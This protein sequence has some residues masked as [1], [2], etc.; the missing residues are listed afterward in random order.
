M[1]PCCLP[2][3]LARGL[4]FAG[5]C[6]GATA[7]C[8]SAFGQA[9]LSVVYTGRTLGYFRYPEQQSRANFDRCIDDPA[10]MSEATRQFAGILRAQVAGAQ[11]LVGMGDNFAMDLDARTF[12]DN[13]VRQ[14]K[15][16]WTWDYLSKPPTWI[17]DK[18]VKGD[19]AK[20]LAAGNGKIPA[21]NVACFLRWAKYDAIVP[22]NADFYYGPE[23]LRMLAR[24]LMT[25]QG[26]AFPKVAMLAANLAVTSV[27]PDANPRIPDYQHE[28]NLLGKQA[29]NY[30]VVQK[31]QGEEPIIQADIPDTVLPW[32]RKIAIHNAFEVLDANQKR[33]VLQNQPDG[34]KFHERPRNPGATAEVTLDYRGDRASQDSQVQNFQV[35]YRF[36]TVEFCPAKDGDPRDPYDLDLKKCTEL[37]IDADATKDGAGDLN[38]DLFYAAPAQVLQPNTNW[39]V[40]L[41]WKNPPVKNSLPLCQL[42]NVHA[43]FLQYPPN[44]GVQIP[45][46]LIK[47]S[48][49]GKIAIFGVVDPGMIASIGRLN[50]AWMNKDSEYDTQLEVLD[51]AV[52]LNQLMQ[53]CE[54][55]ED[56]K[57]ARKILLAHMPAAAASNL[58][59]NIGFHF[60]MVISQTDDAHET[61]DLQVSKRIVANPQRGTDERPP[62]LVTPGSVY[63]QRVPGKI[64]LIAQKATLNR[65]TGCNTGACA[66]WWSLTNETASASYAYNRPVGAG[67][68]LRE[69][70]RTALRQAGVKSS[71]SDPDP[72]E[73]WTSLQILERLATLRMQQ[74]LH[75][76][77]AMIQ[78]RDVFEAKQN[79][80][81]AITPQNLKEVVDRVYWKDDYALSLPLTGATL[82][83]VLQKS[84]ALAAEE[85]N[86]VNIDLERGRALAPLGVFQELATKAILV[87]SQPIQDAALYS[88]AV[89]DYLAFGDTGYTEFLTPAVPPA[90]RLLDFSKLHPI[91]NTVCL[92]IRNALTRAHPEF[93]KADCGPESLKASEYEDESDLKP[94]DTTAGYTAWRQFVAWAIP[95]FQY[96][97]SFPLYAGTSL[98][99]K[100]SQQKPRFSFRV[101]KTDL[102]IA[103]NQHQRTLLPITPPPGASVASI[104]LQASK[105]AGNPIPEVTAPDSSSFRY[106]N[107]TRFRWSGRRFDYFLMDD[108]AFAS[109]KTQ[110]TPFSPNYIRSLSSN[111]LG[112]EGGTLVRLFP[113]LK[114][115]ADLKLLVS[116]RFDTQLSSPLLSLTLHDAAFSN[117]LH[118]LNR[119]YRDLTKVGFRLENSNS[120]IEAG[121][122]GGE[123]FRLPSQYKFGNQVCQ[124][125]TGEDYHN[126]ILSSPPQ[127]TSP[128]YYS[129]DQSLLD[130]VAYYSFA[131]P[132]GSAANLGAPYLAPL[133]A[134]SIFTYSPLSI[135]KTNRTEL[136]AFVNFSLNIPL[137]F[138]DKISYLLEN[139]GD[140]FANGRHDLATDTHYFDELSSSLL[141]AARGN[142]AIKPEFD[143]FVY[144]GKVNGYKIHTYQASLNL[145]YSFDWHSGLPLW[146]TML[147]ANPPTQDNSPTGGR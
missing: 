15:D 145:S 53:E 28:R 63:N 125:G 47:D 82:K 18:D 128:A 137:P 48:P 33:V 124:A 24:F 32:L 84:A 2:F 1:R 65:P 103:I 99:E 44:S 50:Y 11:A 143:V 91:A 110:N 62:T 109:S 9:P 105:F 61:G 23:R 25:D 5:C 83:A 120:W 56:C 37:K 68:T 55:H 135:V 106:D 117:Y 72:T 93:S 20:S 21:D 142:L 64:L 112:F 58:V 73:T 69:A 81:T 95:S 8:L 19:L 57:G 132:A 77:M 100:V 6:L 80:A 88:V 52:A 27:A 89:T 104:D 10:T 146:K 42:F 4:R 96:H 87:N 22:G 108:L 140:L 94:F 35:K 97:R 98:A 59:T 115:D 31:Q 76:D 126:A 111:A 114:Q 136:G 144:D 75:T 29:L 70:A 13:G 14:P 16:L 40:C 134:A 67:L 71:A 107:R 41:R 49:E 86:S 36:D 30:Q 133:S 43:P 60:D 130:C 34:T 90:F 118:N 123:N 45:P 113:K 138:T 85:K 147:Y 39:G 131:A 92:A 79:G 54:A 102:S 38:N 46:Y 17:L 119:T 26:A 3:L 51:P 122:E 66:G 101:E 129:G 12:V 141:I 127:F 7:V 139:K 116:Q 74:L 78:G 121:F